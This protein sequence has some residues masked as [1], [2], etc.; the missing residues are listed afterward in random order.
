MANSATTNRNNNGEEEKKKKKQTTTASASA[1]KATVAHFSTAAVAAA[2]AKEE[3][4]GGGGGRKSGR[5]GGGRRNRKRRRRDDDDE[6]DG[7]GDDDS[8]SSSSSRRRRRRRRQRPVGGPPTTTTTAPK[9]GEPGYLTPTQRR[10]ARKRRQKRQQQQKQK[11]PSFSSTTASSSKTSD[12]SLAYA[13]D[14]TGAPIVRRASAFLSS[15]ATKIAGVPVSPVPL[16]CRGPATGWRTVAKLAVRAARSSSSSPSSEPFLSIGMFH[17]KSRRLVEG[18]YRSACH[19]PDVNE[20][21]ACLQKVARRSGVVPYDDN[22]DDAAK[23]TGGDDGDLRYVVFQ[24]ERSTGTVQ[25]TLVWNPEVASSCSSS[26]SSAATT[27]KTA[28]ALQLEQEKRQRL[29]RLCQRFQ[30]SMRARRRRRNLDGGTCCGDD[31]DD[32]IQK[33]DDR[34]SSSSLL[35]S[36]WVHYNAS[37]KHENAILD[38]AGRWEKRFGADSGDVKE[39]LFPLEGGSF[40]PC[41]P[42]PPPLFFPPQVFR[43]A[44]LDGFARIVAKIRSYLEF[45]CEKFRN[46]N[47]NVL[48]SCVELY[49]GVGTIGLH[50][51]DLFR[52][53]VCSDENPY[54]RPCFEKSVRQ[55]AE[56]RVKQRQLRG[57]ND[58]NSDL[59]IRYESKSATAMVQSGALNEADVVIVDP[60]RK[61]LD[62]EVL[63]GLLLQGRRGPASSTAGAPRRPSLLV[64]VSCGFDA[65]ERDCSR[66]TTAGRWKWNLDHAEGHVL[67]PGSDAI[68]TLAFFVR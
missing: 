48:P 4:S 44:N 46:D 30:D 60:P 27:A 5:G 1:A 39:Y 16:Y 45:F 22:D 23:E 12:P 68:E 41:S 25:V 35:H 26:S 51:T 6:N 54:N 18:S 15:S 19:H 11:R 57:E 3:E 61:G 21:I 49:G 52:S 40:S 8:G 31:D 13:D 20:A 55:I 32:D 9:S 14:P 47:E 34:S 43:Q 66:L 63:D 59:A 17:P 28:K 38:R 42:P 10:N 67:F 33:K 58:R 56:D 2:A 24:L 64:Y 50:L 29:D 65:F 36:L 53:F 7:G 62:A 37:A